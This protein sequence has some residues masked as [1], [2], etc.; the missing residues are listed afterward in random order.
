MNNLKP[1]RLGCMLAAALVTLPAVAADTEIPPR[2]P[3]P[4][5]T[6]DTDGDG[7][8]NQQEFDRVHDERL[9]MR[10]EEQRGYRHMNPPGF[11]EVDADGDG[12]V[13][14]QEMQA[15]RQKR[16]E[17]RRQQRQNMR[18]GGGPGMGMGYGGQ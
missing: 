7:Y 17:M 5:S 11:A 14:E 4:F 9:R 10:S 6:F 8:V 13:S 3:V 15:F 18:P 2:G 12:R 16:Q 1:S